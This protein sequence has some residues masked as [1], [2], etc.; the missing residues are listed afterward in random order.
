MRFDESGPISREYLVDS[1]AGQLDRM[2]KGWDVFGSLVANIG[3][4]SFEL[5]HLL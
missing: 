3:I 5:P 1:S 2:G 4:A